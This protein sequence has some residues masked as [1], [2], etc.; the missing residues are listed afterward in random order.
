ME[1]GVFKK[2][3]RVECIHSD[4]VIEVGDR[5]TVLF[6]D[7]G[8]GVEWDRNVG[9]HDLMDSCENGHGWWI[10]Y[11]CIR[12]EDVKMAKFKV[13]DFAVA[14]EKANE[15]YSVTTKDAVLKVIGID[16]DDNDEIYVQVIHHKKDSS[17]I[18]CKYWVS[19]EHFTVREKKIKKGGVKVEVLKKR[20]VA[21]DMIVMGKLTIAGCVTNIDTVNFIS[22]GS[23][24]I[25]VTILVDG[26]AFMGVAKCDK[27][28]RF[29]V[30]GGLALATS[31]AM[32]QMAEHSEKEII[33]IL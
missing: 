23:R 14:T 15:E 10:A 2:G 1:Y 8:L 27:H 4:G 5:G 11:E 6:N 7:N 13:G 33:D 20:P 3:D 18:G 29:I 25:T 24:I 30:E 21:K 16:A 31:R 32:K 28:D 19:A 22:E 9:G 17:E 26:Q 12:L